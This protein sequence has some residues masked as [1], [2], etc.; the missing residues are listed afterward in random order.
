MVLATSAPYLIDRSRM[1]AHHQFTWAPPSDT[2][3]FFGYMSW[4]EQAARGAWLLK[5]KY[6]A[7]PHSGFLFNPFFLLAGWLSALCSCA[8]GLVFWWIKAVG[9][10][11]FFL[12]FYR[13]LDFLAVPPFASVAATIFVSAT[14]GFGGLFLFLG[15]DSHTSGFPADVFMPEVITFWSLL[16][17]PLFPFSLGLL[18]LSVYWVDRATREPGHRRFWLAGSASGIL[19]LLQPYYIPF[20]FTFA[21]VLVCIRNGWAAI[22]NLVRYF[23]PLLPCVIYMATLSWLE[24]VVAKHSARGAMPSP[25]PIAYLLG[26]GLPLIIVCIGLLL[27]RSLIGRYWQLI[28]WVVVASLLAYLPVWFQRKLIFGCQVALSILAG[29]SLKSIFSR[30]SSNRI[31]KI[32]AIACSFLLLPIAMGTPMYWFIYE[33]GA[34][35]GSPSFVTDDVMAGLEFLKKNTPADS[36]VFAS[37]SVSRLIPAFAGNT[38]IWGHW[39]MSVD[40]DERERWAAR[41][42]GGDSEWSD[43]QKRREF[44]DRDIEYVFL[45]GDLRRWMDQNPYMAK[46]ILAD[47]ETIFQNAS[48]AIYRRPRDL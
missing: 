7:I 40:L 45:D 38:V 18:V 16:R 26:F 14:G 43:E 32:G 1:P 37:N 34:K 41:V 9:V 15:F 11:L 31:T 13:Y 12:A 39:A 22:P 42:F 5:I 21:V 30:C 17:N 24:P 20:I 23:V 48:V 19:T 27:D 3:D 10:V 6:T 28:L 25:P 29:V 2:E 47:A 4:A 46:V 36:I 44:W 35:G 33:S 8:P